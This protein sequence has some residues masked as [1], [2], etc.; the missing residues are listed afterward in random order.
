MKDNERLRKEN[1]TYKTLTI[2]FQNEINNN[3]RKN[4]SFSPFHKKNISH[5][6]TNSDYGIPSISTIGDIYRTNTGRCVNIYNDNI[7]TLSNEKV[8]NTNFNRDNLE[9][10]DNNKNNSKS[11]NIYDKNRMKN[12]VKKIKKKH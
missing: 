9:D 5:I 7:L 12:K 2:M 10:L 8:I 1:E 3:K 11:N 4:G 6:K